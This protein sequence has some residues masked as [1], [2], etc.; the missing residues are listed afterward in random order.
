M[1]LNCAARGAVYNR[2]TFY[3]TIPMLRS[4]SLMPYLKP[5]SISGFIEVFLFFL[6]GLL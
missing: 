5:V 4:Q 3:N 6:L 1:V 2:D